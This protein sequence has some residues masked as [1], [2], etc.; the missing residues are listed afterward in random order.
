MD[1]WN[2]VS[3]LNLGFRCFKSSFLFAEIIN[4]ILMYVPYFSYE[5]YSLVLNLCLK[6]HLARQESEPSQAISH[7][8]TVFTVTPRL[9]CNTLRIRNIS[10]ICIFAIPVTS[11]I[12]ATRKKTVGKR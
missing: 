10:H 6:A 11:N 4:L 8:L 2:W 1:E 12:F 3:A 7:T 9:V 5:A